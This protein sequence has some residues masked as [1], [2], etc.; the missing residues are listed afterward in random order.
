MNDFIEEKID[1][2]SEYKW[3]TLQTYNA[4]KARMNFINDEKRRIKKLQD[5]IKKQGLEEYFKE[6]F[7]PLIE[8]KDIYTQELQEVN[9]APGYIFVHMHLTNEVKSF[10][11]HSQTGLLM[12]GY[13]TPHI[14]SEE[15]IKKLK[16]NVAA[17][18][19][20]NTSFYVG[21]VVKIT[22]RDFADFDGII[23]ELFMEEGYA[24]VSISIFGRNTLI[25][26]R[27][28]DLEKIH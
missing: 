16:N 6:I 12:G 10:L 18:L 21:E 19:N 5:L 20:L 25:K 15:K 26:F 4:L 17:K 2:Y 13:N 28:T 3:Y 8:K 27:L 9:L 14:V 11:M 24:N 7:L 1:N 22:N 23:T